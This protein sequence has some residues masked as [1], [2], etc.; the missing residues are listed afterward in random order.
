[1]REFAPNLAPTSF[2]GS[3]PRRLHTVTS[4]TRRLDVLSV[5]WAQVPAG[6]KCGRIG[7]NPP[8][9][10]TRFGNL[11][12]IYSMRASLTSAAAA[13]L[14]VARAGASRRIQRRGLNLWLSCAVSELV[15]GCRRPTALSGRLQQLASPPVIFELPI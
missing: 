7:P 8:K 2:S 1:M 3:L 13:A 14:L 11:F 6:P 5:T 12:L 15:R 9:A 10:N 4:L